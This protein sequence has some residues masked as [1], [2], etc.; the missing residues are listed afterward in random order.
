MQ[1]GA[2]KAEKYKRAPREERTD[3]NGKVWDSREEML[4][5]TDLADQQANG[6]IAHLQSRVAIPFSIEDRI[7][8]RYYADF[9]YERDGVKIIE[10][11]KGMVT[12]IFLLKKKLIEAM[13]GI[14]ITCVHRVK[15]KSNGG[16]GEW[17]EKVVASGRTTST[18][19]RSRSTETS[20]LLEI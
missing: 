4:R 19:S 5:G 15:K 10:D 7:I 1:E 8:F 16:K 17:V 12:P 18:R 13:H 6:K 20:S 9:T 14:K 3:D 2:V 11:V